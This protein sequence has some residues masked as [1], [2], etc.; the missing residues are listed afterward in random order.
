MS[1]LP[2][3]N[4]RF[5]LVAVQVDPGSGIPSEVAHLKSVIEG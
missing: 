3:Q 1:H 2:E 5:D 4:F